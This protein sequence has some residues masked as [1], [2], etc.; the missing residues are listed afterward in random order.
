MNDKINNRQYGIFLF[1]KPA[2]KI[3]ISTLATI[4]MFIL[5]FTLH[6]NPAQ[7]QVLPSEI[8]EL[9]LPYKYFLRK[10][11]FLYLYKIKQSEP[12]FAELSKISEDF[13]DLI[14]KKEY[15]NAEKWLIQK[16]DHPYY[17]LNLILLYVYFD[18][19]EYKNFFVTWQE[20]VDTKTMQNLVDIFAVRKF[21][22]ALQKLSNEFT[23]TEIKKYATYKIYKEKNQPDM[24]YINFLAWNGEL[25]ENNQSRELYEKA[26]ADWSAENKT[27]DSTRQKNNNPT[28]ESIAAFENDLI[29]EKYTRDMLSRYV[30]Y[31]VEQKNWNKIQKLISEMNW[32]SENEKNVILQKTTEMENENRQKIPT[33]DYIK[34]KING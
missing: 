29:H 28:E 21:L 30:E 6:T 15:K 25:G 14:D 31:L 1:F 32:L 9:E 5:F 13:L 23:S 19:P 7:A 33:G 10:S 4:A 27:G 2:R 8:R 18:Q 17:L 20:S 34:V 16:Y 11:D 22:F 24:V 3:V 26:Y 12:G